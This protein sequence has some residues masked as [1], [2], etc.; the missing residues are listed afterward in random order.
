MHFEFNYNIVAVF[1]SRNTYVVKEV[2]PL[3]FP[4]HS[5]WRHQMET[6][7]ALLAIRAGNSPV[8]VNS[9]H[10]CGALKFS[11]ICVWINDWVSNRE[12]GDLRRDSVHYDVTVMFSAYTSISCAGVP[13]HEIDFGYTFR[14][15]SST[16]CWG[17]NLN[18]FGSVQY[19]NAV[20]GPY[21]WFNTV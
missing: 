12:A 16:L 21:N 15:S 6:F 7:S 2:Y 19:H 20:F 18:F 14:Y 10:K 8:P 13:S 3:A 9:P 5:W 4:W 1:M 17:I 11:L